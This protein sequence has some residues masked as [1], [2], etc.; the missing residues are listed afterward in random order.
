MNNK[1]KIIFLIGILAVM[2]GWIWSVSMSTVNAQSN[3]IIKVAKNTRG[4]FNVTNGAIY[5]GSLFDTTYILNNI[6]S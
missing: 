1:L 2:L 3:T 5:V 4:N 6:S